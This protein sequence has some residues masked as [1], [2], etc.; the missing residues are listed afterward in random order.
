M[1]ASDRN[2]SDA[3]CWNSG[4]LPVSMK[5][6]NKNLLHTNKYY[7]RENKVFGAAELGSFSVVI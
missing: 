4:E 7:A 5:T 3:N 1:A 2:G 6:R